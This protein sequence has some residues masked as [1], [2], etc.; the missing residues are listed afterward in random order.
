MQTPADMAE[1]LKG[2]AGIGY[3][4]V[5]LAGLGPIETAELRA[6]LDAAG[7]V[8]VSAHK[9]YQRIVE[10]TEDLAAEMTALGAK[11]VACAGLAKD[12]RDEAGFHKGAEGLNAAGAKLAAKGITLAYHNHGF[13]FERF[14]DRLGIEILYGESDAANLKA[15]LDTY[16]VQNGGAS[17]AAWCRRMAGRLPMLHLKDAGI[18]GG[19]M[20]QYEIGEG[21][22]DWSAIV[23]AARE[24]G[25]QWFIVE[26]GNAPHEPMESLRIS[27]R[28]LKEMGL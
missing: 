12:L 9:P 25:V 27:Y 5:E 26:L 17:P 28:N 10:E 15:Q 7:L 20:G 19:K 16:W 22:L 13:E 14:G 6:L 4:G 8:C 24:A 21:N 3:T 2:V 23:P 18:I 11:F 1:T